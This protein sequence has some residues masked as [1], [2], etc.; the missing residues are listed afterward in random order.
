MIVLYTS[1]SCA[2]V[3]GTFVVSS[4]RALECCCLAHACANGSGA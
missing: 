3:T 2:I 1:L 4:G